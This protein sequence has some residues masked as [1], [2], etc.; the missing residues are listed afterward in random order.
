MQ[1]LTSIFSTPMRPQHVI[2][3]FPLFVI[4]PLLFTTSSIRNATDDS[5]RPDFGKSLHPKEQDSE[6]GPTND[7]EGRNGDSEGEDNDPEYQYE[8]IDYEEED[9]PHEDVDD[10]ND[11]DSDDGAETHADNVS[12]ATALKVFSESSGAQSAKTGCKCP[13]GRNLVVCIDGTANQFS[14]KVSV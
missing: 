10:N 8:H 14:A 5:S 12:T 6:A 2:T 11:N 9:E 13:S 1:A 4:Y 7:D 3:L